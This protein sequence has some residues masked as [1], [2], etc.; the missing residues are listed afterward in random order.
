MNE[1][2]PKP[3][4]EKPKSAGEDLAMAIK[5]RDD[6]DLVFLKDCDNDDLK[7][8]ADILIY[9]KNGKKR[10]TQE[11][12]DERDFRHCNGDYQKVWDLIAGELQLYGGDSI[13]NMFRRWKGVPYREILENVCDKM[14]VN[15][16]KKSTTEKIEMNLIMKVV[17]DALEKMSEEEKRELVKEMKLDVE[18]PTVQVIIAAL[19]AAIVAG[20]FRSYQIALII[21]NAIARALLGR[22]L[23]ITTN[24][25]LTRVMSIFAGP[26][27]IVINI[28]L[29]LPLITSA[30]YRVT[31]PAT[32]QVAY[33]RQKMLHGTEGESS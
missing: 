19:Q 9:K 22:G 28:V 26:V 16:N 13:V 21:A 23:T 31:I 7:V 25:M 15:Y 2:A 1:V 11:L 4:R 18:Q 14:G 6:E 17:E 29:T 20:G 27:A 5:Y 33:M 3:T 32:I 12:A 24:A 8:L 10:F 30:A